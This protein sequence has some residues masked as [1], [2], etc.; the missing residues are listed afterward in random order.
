MACRVVG[1]KTERADAQHVTRRFVHSE[2]HHGVAPCP[3]LSVP[4]HNLVKSSMSYD[5]VVRRSLWRPARGWRHLANISGVHGLAKTDRTE[6]ANSSSNRDGY[7]A[8]AL[9]SLLLVCLMPT[10]DSLGI[11]ESTTALLSQ[12]PT[13]QSFVTTL[14]AFPGSD[15]QFPLG[16]L[17]YWAGARLL[18]SSEFALRALSSVWIAFAILVLW[19][20]ARVVG[21]PYLPLLFACHPFVWYYAN[22]A[23]PYAMQIALGALLALSMALVE[24]D[25]PESIRPGFRLLIVTAP[26][27]CAT[28]L[29]AVIPVFV[30]SGIAFANLYRARFR[31]AV[32]DVVRLTLSIGVIGITGAYYG[33]TLLAGKG[34]QTMG[35]W[36][37]GLRNVVFTVYELLG[38]SGFGPGRTTL[39]EAALEEGIPGVVG[40]MTHPRA[41]FGLGI[42]SLVYFWALLALAR[43]VRSNHPSMRRS[44]AI[45]SCLVVVASIGILFC[46]SVAVGFPFWGRH[47]APALPF[48]VVALAIALD[49]GRGGLATSRL[50]PLVSC[51]IL[52]TSS[53]LVR[54]H[55][56]HARVDYRSAAAAAISMAREGAT[57]WWSASRA[58][59]A[60]YRLPIC[61][62]VISSDQCVVDAIN[63]SVEE[64]LSL[65][66][67]DVIVCGQPDLF[68]Q[69]GA[70]RSYVES[71]GPL[72]T[73]QIRGFWLHTRP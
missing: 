60:Y 43:C 19:Q 22:E 56:D 35:I 5:G 46:L 39:R 41:L 26:L 15:P 17:Y 42:L 24:R 28:S 54:L 36:G 18:G 68:D 9:A 34:A 37:V 29:L 59:A 4:A 12:E 50:M 47:L 13:L 64:I 69:T 31:L 49:Q 71:H 21:I 66:R 27:L 52:L 73:E 7:G 55:P 23:R 20:V 1:K 48:V 6:A 58:P 32:G 65:P 72:K 16:N 44:L 57:V 30:V 70:L 51:A 45:S 10:G 33:W 67:P 8:I 38:V 62:T 14:L 2:S 11:D 53:L 63:K 61:D 40:L 3:I 25:T